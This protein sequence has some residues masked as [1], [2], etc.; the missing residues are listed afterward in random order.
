MLTPFIG[1][2]LALA[3]ATALLVPFTTSAQE[4]G[5]QLLLRPAAVTTAAAPAAPAMSC[6]ACKSEF[7]SRVDTSVRGVNKPIITVE[8]HLC[9]NCSTSQT[10]V[11]TG[12]NAKNVIVHNCG[13]KVASCCDSTG[14][15]M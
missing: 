12:K 14:A 4:K 7:I 13:S 9:G 15:G 8:K 2:G 1:T 10:L 5:A 11:G 6:P 3:T